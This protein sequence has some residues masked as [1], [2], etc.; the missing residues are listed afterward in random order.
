MTR[1]PRPQRP[2]CFADAISDHDDPERGGESKRP[3]SIIA[4]RTGFMNGAK[5]GFTLS[6]RADEAQGALD[7]NPTGGR[8]CEEAFH[9]SRN[10]PMNHRGVRLRA[11]LEAGEPA[12]APRPASGPAFGQDHYPRTAPSPPPP[13][14][15]GGKVSTTMTTFRGAL[16]GTILSGAPTRAP[17]YEQTKAGRSF[18]AEKDPFY[19]SAEPGKG[20]DSGQPSVSLQPYTRISSQ[21]LPESFRQRGQVLRQDV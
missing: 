3:L 19:N 20:G 10:E 1:P 15:S 7:T 14:A 2:S 18:H 12:L 11:L 16:N 21:R 13:W 9:P 8:T 17:V 6:P 5:A 4:A